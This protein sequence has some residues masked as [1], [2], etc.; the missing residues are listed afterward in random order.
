M[1]LETHPGV[2]HASDVLSEER[3]DVRSC[4]EGEDVEE[5]VTEPAVTGGV[6]N[7]Y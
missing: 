6:T 4:D 1:I 3:I 2:P 7:Q 5:G